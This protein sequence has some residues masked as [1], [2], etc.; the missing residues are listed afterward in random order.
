MPRSRSRREID[1]RRIVGHKEAFFRIETVNEYLVLSQIGHEGKAAG[2]IVFD[3]VGVGGE[4][5][6]GVYARATV[7]EKRSRLV[8]AAIGTNR[9]TS[10]AAA[11][12][13]G[14]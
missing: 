2:G 10:H 7:L 14:H 9:E 12:V 1:K 5:A 6:G 4:L 8:K 3:A 13:V 11:G